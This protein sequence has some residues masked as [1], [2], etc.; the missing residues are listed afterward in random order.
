MEPI[1]LI[2]LRVL[3]ILSAI[4]ILGGAICWRFALI[5]ASLPLATDT[6]E[7]LRNAIAAAWRPFMLSAIAALLISGFYN[8]IRKV[9]MGVPKGYHM[10]FGIKFLLALHV[11]AVGFII[12]NPANSKRERQ[13]T[14]IIASGVVIVILSAILRYLTTK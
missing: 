8:F 1:L 12:T 3:H 13:L 5:P 14:G 4:T 10:V 6:R 11:I 2:S 7:K 9:S